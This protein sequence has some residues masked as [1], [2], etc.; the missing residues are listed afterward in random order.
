MCHTPIVI[1]DLDVTSIPFVASW[2]WKNSRETGVLVTDCNYWPQYL[3]DGGDQWFQLKPWTT[4]I[5][6]CARYCTSASAQLSKR[7]AIMIHFLLLYRLMLSWQPLGQYDVNTHSVAAS[8]GFQVSHGPPPLG[9]ARSIVSA[10]QLSR[11]NGLHQRCI[12]SLS[13]ILK[14]S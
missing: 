4:S 9:D 6:Q 7:L 14:L 5:G 12:W 8:S 10:H 2:R 1:R 3:P 13:M 11:P